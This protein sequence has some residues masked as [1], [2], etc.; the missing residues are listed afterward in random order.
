MDMFKFLFGFHEDGEK[1]KYSEKFQSKSSRK[2]GPGRKHFETADKNARRDKVLT[3]EE[4]VVIR[5]L[6]KFERMAQNK[7]LTRFS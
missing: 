4:G 7:M 3:D 2:K 6:S 1:K 5:R